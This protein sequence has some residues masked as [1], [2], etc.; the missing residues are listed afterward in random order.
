MSRNSPPP[1]RAVGYCQILTINAGP[2][3]NLVVGVDL[4]RMSYIGRRTV[5]VLLAFSWY[6]EDREYSRKL[7]LERV[8]FV[9]K[10]E[11]KF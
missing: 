9:N 10:R 1:V 4:K 6:G 11:R 7:F 3:T 8:R 5:Q 2:D